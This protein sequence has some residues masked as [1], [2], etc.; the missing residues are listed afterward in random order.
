MFIPAKE[1]SLLITKRYLAMEQAKSSRS[2]KL[3]GG[4]YAN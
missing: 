4:S 3:T 2:F 1:E